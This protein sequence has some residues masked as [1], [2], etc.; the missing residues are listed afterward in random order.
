V[1]QER[2][3]ADLYLVCTA[4]IW[5]TAFV[6]QRV[7]AENGAVFLFNGV[8]FLVGGLALLPV[9]AWQRR[10]GAE[11]VGSKR[12]TA[13]TWQSILL[14]GTV[15]FIASGFQQFGLRYTSAGNAGFITGLYVVLIPVLQATFWRQAVSVFTWASSIVAALGMF[16]LSTSGR[17]VINPGDA[18]ELAGAFVWALH[19]ILIG[20]F[21][22]Q[23]SVVTLAV[24]QYFIT[25]LLSLVAGLGLESGGWGPV[26]EVWW[27]VI[28]TGV[29]SIGLGYTF[30][31][32]AQK[33]APPADA[34]ILLSGEAVFAALFGWLLLGE[35]LA[36]LQV[37]GC[38]LILAAMLLAQSVVFRRAA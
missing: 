12:Q 9:A 33:V 27:A 23:I 10:A 34:A 37:L 24:G 15:L 14:I 31:A 25:G 36:P 7:A 30:Q 38:G 11:P 29:L 20:K 26:L 17:L 6:A 3:K 28:Y 35:L 22:R 21:V 19:V 16:L 4:A 1:D 2:F 32:I 18:L 8:R 13:R 5:G